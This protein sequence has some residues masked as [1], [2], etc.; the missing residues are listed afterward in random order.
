MY[1]HDDP[2]PHPTTPLHSILYIAKY[3]D[4]CMVALHCIT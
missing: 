2:D 1:D 4:T 3:G